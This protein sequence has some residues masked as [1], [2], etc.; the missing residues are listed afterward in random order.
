VLGPVADALPRI[1]LPA[2]TLD[3]L[4][5]L[6]PLALI[7]SFVVMVQTAA[8]TRSVASEPEGPPDLNRDF[9]GI[10]AANILAGL[11]GAFPVNA[12]PPSTV[13]VEESGA[14]SQIAGLT[15]AALVFGLLAFGGPILPHVPQAALAGVLV[16]IA[17]RIFRLREMIAIYR[18]A[19]AEFVLI[20]VTMAAIVALPIQ[21][22]VAV[23]IVLS[24][25]HGMWTATR[26]HTI[27]FVH[28]P[29]TS[30]WWAPSAGLKGETLP[31]VV[32]IA[33]QAPLF[34]LNAYGFRHGVLDAIARRPQ[35]PG[36]VVLEAGN[37]TT[38]DYTGSKILAEIIR[39]CQ[40]SGIV[41]AVARLESVRA[42]EAF[43]R[44]GIVDMIGQ[45]HL[46]LSVDE[47]VK[48]LAGKP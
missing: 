5:R 39:H 4:A 8:T 36:L 38:I 11:F 44:L 37:I 23:G 46:F 16:F 2:M 30:I 18:R 14:R 6:V 40:G 41:F 27:E 10:G 34:F 3:G 19:L 9:L 1:A 45:D 48:A 25:M 42:Q 28:V 22:G 29:G 12:S 21:T 26:A 35:P 24:L 32:V 31:R 20:I 17:C 47:A 33:F 13:I 43:S 7:V 15:A